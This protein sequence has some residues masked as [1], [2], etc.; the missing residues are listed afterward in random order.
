MWKQQTSNSSSANVALVTTY[1]HLICGSE[2]C[3]CWY[4]SWRCM[5]TYV[6]AQCMHIVAFS[7][8]WPTTSTVFS[9]SI[10]FRMPWKQ[11]LPLQQRKA[12]ELLG[13]ASY[14][15][16]AHVILSH[17]PDVFIW[18]YLET[19]SMI[20]LCSL[21]VRVFSP[22]SLLQVLWCSQWITLKHLCQRGCVRSK[23]CI[24]A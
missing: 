8:E 10:L 1:L 6:S 5:V 20:I 23:L 22:G 19:A 7:M 11:E 2:V 16:I 21:N 14:K 18:V 24:C 4:S 12:V 13:I 15:M 9:W 3:I 17:P